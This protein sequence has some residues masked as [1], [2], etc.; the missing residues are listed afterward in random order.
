MADYI[1]KLYQGQ[2]IRTSDGKVVAPCQSD[3]DPDFI[4]YHEWIAAGNQPEEDSSLP[5]N[6]KDVVNAVQS[7]LNITAQSRGYDDILSLCTYA[8]SSIPKFSGEGQAGVNWRDA[9][10]GTCYTILAQVEQGIVPMPT[11]IDDILV[12]LPGISWP[13]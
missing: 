12:Q 5:I 13:D 2:V 3:Q 9:V 11:S 8:T 10:W 4:T 7:L 1:I 6:E